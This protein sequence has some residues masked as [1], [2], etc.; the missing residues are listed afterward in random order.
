R[1]S[2]APAAAPEALQE[3]SRLLG[4]LPEVLLAR[5]E[6]SGPDLRVLPPVD[7]AR[8]ADGRLPSPLGDLASDPLEVLARR[9]PVRERVDRVLDGDGAERLEAPP[10]LDPQV[11]WRRGDPVDQQEPGALGHT[12]RYSSCILYATAV[13]YTVTSAA[14]RRSRAGR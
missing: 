9:I 11:G 12:R 7:E 3:L 2:L 10:D 13:S 4:D 8:L 14:R 5:G 6:E 1:G